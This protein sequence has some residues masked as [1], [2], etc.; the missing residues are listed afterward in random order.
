MRKV[1]TATMNNIGIPTGLWPT[2]ATSAC[3]AQARSDLMFV[4]GRLTYRLWKDDKGQQRQ[5]TE[6]VAG[7]LVLLDRRPEALPAEEAGVHADG[8][9]LPF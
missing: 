1:I 6:V 9:E 3:Q 4:A 2:A 8:D 7:E 5:V